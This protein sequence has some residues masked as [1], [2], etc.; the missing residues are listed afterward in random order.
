VIIAGRG[1]I[2]VLDL[3]ALGDPGEDQ[4]ERENECECP[5]HQV[6][7]ESMSHDLRRG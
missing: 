3:S 6:A 1:V 2:D 7:S 5:P 4:G